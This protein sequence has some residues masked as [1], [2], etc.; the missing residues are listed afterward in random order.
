MNSWPYTPEVYKVAKATG[1]WCP[2]LGPQAL[3]VHL[4]CSET[5]YREG[6]FGGS[7]GGGK[8]DCSIAINAERIPN[9]NYRSLVL[10]RNAD[11]LDDYESRCEEKFQCFNVK[12]RRKPMVLR[13]GSNVQ[14]TK[15]AVIKGN[16]LKDKNSYIKYQ[17]QEFDRIFIEE[18]THIPTELLYNQVMMS[19]RSKHKELYPQMILTTNPGSVGHGWVKK[20]FV[21]PID[22]NAGEDYE[23]TEEPNGDI[24]F[25]NAKIEWWQRRYEWQTE[26]YE[27]RVTIWNEIHDKEFDTWRIFVPATLDDNPVLMDNDPAYGNMLNQLKDTDEAL[28]KAWRLG[29]WEVFAGQVFT[30]FD[31]NKHI[32]NNFADLGI[33][34]EDFEEAVKV[35]SMDWGYS[36][37]TAIYITAWINGQA[38]TYKE[39][40]G[41]KTLATDWGKILYD[42]IMDN[43]TRIDYFI[44]PDDMES[45]KNGKNS[46][47]DDI[48]EWINRL[49]IDL[50]P[51]VEK[52]G[53]EA[54]SRMIRQQATHKFLLKDPVIKIFKS[55]KKLIEVLPELVYDED[56]KEEIDTDT[57]HSLTNPYDGWSYGLRWL[58]ERKD[59]E[60]LKPATRLKKPNVGITSGDTY[61]DIG[62]D[63]AEL[64]KKEMTGGRSWKYN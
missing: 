10:R 16:H 26:D 50:Q 30:E 46:P 11:D 48:M 52:M 54:G 9:P 44:Y 19:C 60:L 41:N 42:Y 7:R 18:L 22:Y 37:D 40:I 61:S 8:T 35:I 2:M 58:Y 14:N 12:A 17:G 39:W 13:F 55:C 15:G 33:S 57:D 38:V 34:S 28:Y 45:M 31:R 1:K 3:F 25:E 59:G 47:I 21:K 5:K 20:R 64:V 36:D 23:R 24:K 51:K 27:D 49:P 62:L 43:E 4:M 32:I 56:R 6:C 53:R 63:P 29:D